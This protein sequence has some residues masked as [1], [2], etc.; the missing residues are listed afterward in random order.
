MSNNNN[1]MEL[2]NEETRKR[3]EKEEKKKN[4]QKKIKEWKEKRQEAKEDRKR[5]K[6]EKER[7]KEE[8]RREKEA[9]NN[10]S[11]PFREQTLTND[12]IMGKSKGKPVLTPQEIRRKKEKRKKLIRNIMTIPEIIIVVLLALFLKNKYI[13]YS[14]NVHQILN[15]SVNSYIYEIHRDNDQIKVLKN[16][17]VTCPIEPCE[18]ENISEYEIKF[19]KNQMRALRFFIDWKFKFKSN[20]NKTITLADI[21]TDYGKRS[22]FSMIHNNSSFLG[23]ETYNKYT[24]TDYEQLSSY[25]KRGYRYQTNTKMLYI[26]LGE[27]TTSGYALVVNSAYKNGEDIYFYVKEQKP[28]TTD[29]SISLITHPLVKIELQEDIKNIYVYDVESGEEYANLDAPTVP[30]STQSRKIASI[31]S[32]EDI[33]LASILQKEI[34]KD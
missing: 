13:K 22:I 12:V 32:N 29:D 26:A 18:V 23:F 21:K 6:E 15:Y 28:E 17:K 4:F 24:V 19:D 31:I 25:T 30:A 8:E 33:D 7:V 20:Q 27:K 5:A 9:K 3:K 11:D 10:N 14:K 34:K 1:L 2:N 16:K